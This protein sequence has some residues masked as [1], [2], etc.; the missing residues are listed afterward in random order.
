MLTR[1]IVVA[2]FGIVL[3][4]LESRAAGDELN[5][6]RKRARCRMMATVWL[7]IGFGALATIFIIP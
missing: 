7:T 2:S 6:T 4:I 1:L 3:G 5:S